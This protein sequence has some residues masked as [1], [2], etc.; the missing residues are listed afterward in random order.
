MA[1][2]K[3]Q[4]PYYTAVPEIALRQSN[5]GVNPGR[6]YSDPVTFQ[7]GHGF[8]EAQ[9]GHRTDFNTWTDQQIK[10][11]LDLRGEDYDD[12]VD[13]A[14][15]VQRAEECEGATGP[16]LQPETATQATT[17]TEEEDDPL[18]AFMASINEEVDA[19]RPAAKRPKAGIELDEDEDNVADFM[20]VRKQN[21]N[22]ALANAVAAQG[23]GSDD[24]VYAA[25]RA[26]DGAEVEYDANDNPIMADRSKTVGPMP[27]LDHDNIEYEEFAKDFYT[28]DPEIAAMP[29]AEVNALRRELAIRVSGFDAPKPIKTFQHC[30]FDKL[31]MGA[32]AKAGYEKPTPIQAQALPAAL[33][34]RD[35]LG[36]AKTGSGKTAAFVLP[37][38]VHIM[39]Q[40]EL[41]KGEGPIGIIVAPTRELSEQIH[42]ETRKF[43]KPYN[44]RVCAAFGGLSKYEQM[45]DLKAGSE[46]AVCTPGRMID[47]IK[48]KACTMLRATYL[49]FDEADRMFDM[50]F[51]PQVR[52]LIGQIRP[53]RQTLLFSATMPNK[54][55]RLV[56]DALTSPVRITVG[57]VGAA[58][59]D[60]RQVVEVLDGDATK[61]HWLTSRLQGFIDA[62]DV[63]VFANQKTRVDELTQTLQGLGIRAAAIH[64]DMDQHSRM[65]V[66]H[67]FKAGKHH[68]VVATDVAARGLD[69]KSIKSVV[70]Y[71][72]AKEIDTH[73][74]RVGRTGRA[75]DKDGIAYTLI[76]PRE[77]RM[78]GDLVASLTA[79]NQEVPQALHDLALK[80]GRYRK[81]QQRQRGG[82]GGG[83]GGGRRQV[84]GAGLGFDSGSGNTMHTAPV[85]PGFARGAPAATPETRMGFAAVPATAASSMEQARSEMRRTV[86]QGNFRGG[87][88][89]SGTTGGDLSFSGGFSARPASAAPDLNSAAAKQ[90]LAAAQ[91]VAA[92]LSALGGAATASAA[93]M[94]L[95]QA[96]PTPSSHGAPL[97]S[98]RR[99]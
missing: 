1:G 87:F 56:R 93:G 5:V 59:E 46:V 53:D 58:N 23:Y 65:A 9:Q 69:I 98:C 42:K 64:G 75:G 20:E 92:R 31:L 43:S 6:E 52:S 91:A 15:L 80:D 99:E 76:T 49:V 50:G 19:N 47:L 40:A 70:N 84:G 89:S 13:R 37:M 83:R 8:G 72:V 74:H 79:V 10:G 30:G 26:I 44:L 45:K 7:P 55:E 36:I 90:A 57:E 94:T 22:M 38:L 34:G 60:I 21:A 61:T 24:E 67:D 25:A 66:L 32:I 39:D 96:F 4:F 28:P 14:M 51:E 78:A 12:C 62:G 71:D 77:T 29:P 82:K 3:R 16:A 81:G 86:Q 48:T 85:M 97:P 17:A 2:Q 88:V 27:P 41:N 95:Q 54:V 63:L 18:D 68:V 33:S 35:V 11:F 73:V